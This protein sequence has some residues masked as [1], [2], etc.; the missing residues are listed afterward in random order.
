MTEQLGFA[1]VIDEA[2]DHARILAVAPPDGNTL[3]AL[4]TP[5]PGSPQQDLVGRSSLVLITDDI[6]GR[7]DK[8]VSRLQHYRLS[9]F[10]LSRA[11][12]WT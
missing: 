11:N 3:V 5:G 6:L 8:K 9:I 12:F 2:T 7:K 4:V 10:E 1:L